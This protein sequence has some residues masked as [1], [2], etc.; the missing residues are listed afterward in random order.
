MRPPSRWF[1]EGMSRNAG[2]I[3]GNSF[4]D[5]FRWRNGARKRRGQ[6]SMASASPLHAARRSVTSG[7]CLRPL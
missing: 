1:G 4:Q 2:V 6:S 7:R 3:F 5:A